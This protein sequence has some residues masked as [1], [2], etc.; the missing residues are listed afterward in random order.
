MASAH[1]TYHDV[2]DTDQPALCYSLVKVTVSHSPGWKRYNDPT[3][4][5]FTSVLVEIYNV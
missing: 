5:K 2:T 3:S 1:N 4:R